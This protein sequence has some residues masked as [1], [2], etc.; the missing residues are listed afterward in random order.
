M[1]YAASKQFVSPRG[2]SAAGGDSA[3]LCW[4][5]DGGITAARQ[6]TWLLSFIDI[7]ALLLTLLVLLLAYQ[8][9][10][11]RLEQ[12]LAASAMQNDTASA[13]SLQTLLTANNASRLLPSVF[14][15]AQGYA[16]PGEGLLPQAV[17]TVAIAP[18][19][20]TQGPV[21]PSEPEAPQASPEM[22]PPEPAVQ[23]SVAAPN[24]EIPASFESV[25]RLAESDPAAVS[26]SVQS[27]APPAV[28]A[29]FA[30]ASSP[31]AAA[32]LDR[33][34]D[35]LHSSQLQDRIEVVVGSSDVSLEISDS[36]LFA[37]AS[38]ALSATGTGLLDELAGLLQTLP[39]ALSVEGH[40]DNVPIQTARY[41]SNWE[42]SSAR[43]AAVTRALI[44]KG[45]AP[46]RIRAIGYGDTRPRD[47]NGSTAGRARNR[48]VTFVL[49]LAGD[50]K[51][52]IPAQ[53]LST[54]CAIHQSAA[55]PWTSLTQTGIAKST[56]RASPGLAGGSR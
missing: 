43:A 4:E 28:P 55:S 9:Q 11:R 20:A 31:A 2:V 36:I 52:L 22:A 33:V 38:A 48:R 13:V 54:L 34:M 49:Q 12:E 7:L 10:D 42:L 45:I 40:S 17:A 23:A 29:S 35:A 47:D 15:A 50:L 5:L 39:Y 41:P 3:A 26:V 16:V 8:D 19:T 46:E 44:E 6:E 30:T 32:P 27:A 56:V 1:D 18:V 37:P 14:D 21:A 51:D 53:G 24:E 25:D